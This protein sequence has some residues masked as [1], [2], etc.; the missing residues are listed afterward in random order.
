M[1]VKL[2]E[3][4]PADLAELLRSANH[5]V[6]TLPEEELGGAKDPIVS[7]AVTQEDRLLM[8][9]DLDFADIRKYPVG[10]HAGIVVF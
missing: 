5:D 1:R 4:L 7:A 8:T 2:D 3:N 9:F 6:V 10:T